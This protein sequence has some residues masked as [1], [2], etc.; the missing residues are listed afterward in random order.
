MH[1]ILIKIGPVTLYSYGLMVALGFGLAVYLAARNAGAFGLK[2]GDVIDTLLFVLIG[3][4]IGARL[5]YVLLNIGY[6]KARPI[7]IF[8]LSRGGLVYYGGFISALVAA[9]IYTSRKK[10]AFWDMMDLLGPYIALGQSVGRIGCF[11]NGCCYGVEAPEDFPLGVYFPSKTPAPLVPTQLYSSLALLAVFFILRAI[12]KNRRFR[13]EVFLA[14]V[15]IYSFQR[16][17]MEYLRGDNPVITAGLT[18]SQLTS[19]AVFFASLAAY[20]I[21]YTRWKNTRS[22]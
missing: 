19:V 6:F 10:I 12:Q 11:L 16:F 13:A 8:Y 20:V 18:F 4:L 21:L 2:K 15:S 9:L 7:E 17:F 1:P 3:G 14:Y 22:S 5:L